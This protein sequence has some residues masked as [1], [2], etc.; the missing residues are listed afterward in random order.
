MF[1][2]LVQRHGSDRSLVQN[3]T[4]TLRYDIHVERPV[5]FASGLMESP[6][7]CD[8]RITDIRGTEHAAHFSGWWFPEKVNP[9]PSKVCWRMKVWT[10]LGP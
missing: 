8:V 4:L 3:A 1:W 10:W 9:P 7:V 6:Y 5:R 2:D